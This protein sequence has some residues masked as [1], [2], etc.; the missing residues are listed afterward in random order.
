MYNWSQHPIKKWKRSLL[1][2]KHSD[3]SLYLPRAVQGRDEQHQ[4][5]GHCFDHDGDRVL[6]T[7]NPIAML[8]VITQGYNLAGLVQH[9]K[10]F[11]LLEW[12]GAHCW[13]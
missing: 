10:L 8:I 9:I 4:L 13:T 1:R 3:W 11:D 5:Q 7:P 12:P 2:K 6:Q